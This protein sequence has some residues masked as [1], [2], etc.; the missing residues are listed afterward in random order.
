MDILKDMA[1][2]YSQK[3]LLLKHGEI[4]EDKTITLKTYQGDV[5]VRFMDIS[6]H[7]DISRII[8]VNG[9]VIDIHDVS[10][11]YREERE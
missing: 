6:F 10:E 4:I 3:R 11:E 1:S 9:E 7:G 5:T 8:S 2:Y